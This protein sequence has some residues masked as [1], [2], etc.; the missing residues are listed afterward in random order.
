MAPD[1]TGTR[2]TLALILLGGCALALLFL[3]GMVD[4]SGHG[5]VEAIFGI[6]GLVTGIAVILAA[7][8]AWPLR[9]LGRRDDDDAGNAS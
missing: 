1:P 6:S 8:L 4:G 3:D 9:A 5:G 7:L 2:T